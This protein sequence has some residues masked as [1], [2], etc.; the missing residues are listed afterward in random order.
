MQLDFELEGLDRRRTQAAVEEALEKYR[1]CK[2]ITFEE[3]EA[4]TTQS[5]SDMPRSYTGTT[6]DQ[7]A[8]IAVHNV[9]KPAQRRAYCEWI[10]RHVKKLPHKERMLIVERYMKDDYVKDFAVYQLLEVSQGTYTKIRWKAF[11]KLALALDIAVA[12]EK[13]TE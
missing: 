9:D 2:T 8:N 1:I 3:R 7:T 13:T 6:S 4:S 10:E 12:I 11:Y 5:Y